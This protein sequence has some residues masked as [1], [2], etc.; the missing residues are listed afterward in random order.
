MVAVL[1][2]SSTFKPL[3]LFGTM[4]SSVGASVAYLFK[5][6]KI[7]CCCLPIP[8]VMGH[9]CCYS[10]RFKIPLY[11]KPSRYTGTPPSL[12]HPIMFRNFSR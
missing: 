1:D 2:W 12:S 9:L 5:D 7:V 3:T 11:P 8:A 4:I 6:P 10:W